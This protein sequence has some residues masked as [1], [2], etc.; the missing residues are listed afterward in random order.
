MPFFLFMMIL[1]FKMSP[2]FIIEVL[3]DIPKGK[4]LA[5]CLTEKTRVLDKLCLGMS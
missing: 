5:L 2:K 3:P 4:K 1:L